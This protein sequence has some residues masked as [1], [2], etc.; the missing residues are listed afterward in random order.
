MT[1]TLDGT[2]GE[3]IAWLRKKKNKTQ[4]EMAKD[5]NLTRNTI[6]KWEAN[7]QEIKGH[8]LVALAEYFNVSC[9][10]ILTGNRPEY[11]Q[12]SNELGLSSEA[13]ES[14][15]YLKKLSDYKFKNGITIGEL[16]RDASLY[17]KITEN[18]WNQF[19]SKHGSM[20]YDAKALYALNAVMESDDFIYLFYNLYNFLFLHD[21]KYFNV[22]CG[23]GKSHNYILDG[24]EILDFE[25]ID[26]YG[27]FVPIYPKDAKEISL[28]IIN[29][30]L[31]RISRHLSQDFK[32]KKSHDLTKE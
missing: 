11:A 20:P 1:K 17:E 21:V 31:Y 30:S 6:S 3:R 7:I 15:I 32:T 8:D 28:S 12:L 4:V 2:I 27:N 22:Y 5:L 14:L 13:I 25:L 10:E 24:K 23:D 26:D 29:N 18:D 9:D 16:A 19:Y